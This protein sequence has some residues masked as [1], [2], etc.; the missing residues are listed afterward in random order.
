MMT[1]FEMGFAKRRS[2]FHQLIGQER[3]VPGTRVRVLQQSGTGFHTASDRRQSVGTLRKAKAETRSP[4]R[5][6]I[7]QLTWPII[8]TL[9]EIQRS[10]KRSGRDD[11]NPDFDSVNSYRLMLN[12]KI[13]LQ[14]NDLANAGRVAEQLE[15]LIHSSSSWTDI[16]VSYIFL[17]HFFSRV[18]SIER[19]GII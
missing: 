3:F 18:K 15:A 2:L 16:A 5:A 17:G 14:M 1:S 7:V 19:P 8:S 13:M 4:V 10:A 9:K 11:R 12:L 6:T